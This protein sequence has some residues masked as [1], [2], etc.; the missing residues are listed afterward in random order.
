ML[1]TLWIHCFTPSP[2]LASKSLLLRYGNDIRSV[3]VVE[4]C[5]QHVFDFFSNFGWIG[6]ASFCQKSRPQPKGAHGR[7]NMGGTC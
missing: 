6:Q 2:T 3:Y 5:R 1:A 7:H 4:A